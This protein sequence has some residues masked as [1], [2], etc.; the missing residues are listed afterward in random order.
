MSIA[1]EVLQ[2]YIYA[3]A[4]AG[5]EVIEDPCVLAPNAV[6][7]RLQQ[8]SKTPVLVDFYG[9]S[10]RDMQL[11]IVAGATVFSPQARAPRPLTD[12]RTMSR[13]VNV[14]GCQTV[15]GMFGENALGRLAALQLSSILPPRNV[16]ADY[17]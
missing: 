17:A 1:F 13:L 14:S 4:V 7:A 8:L 2:N 15:V 5:A 10:T 16:R 9:W 11:F 6:L 3:S 12:V